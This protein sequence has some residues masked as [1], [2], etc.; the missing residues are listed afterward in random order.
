MLTTQIDLFIIDL[1]DL[2]KAI[3][4]EVKKEENVFI[5]IHLLRNTVSE[6]QMTLLVRRSNFATLLRCADGWERM[7]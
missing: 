3:R 6:L 7:S 5:V 4:S 1:G 2:I